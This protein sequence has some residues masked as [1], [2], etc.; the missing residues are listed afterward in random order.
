MQRIVT[1]RQIAKAK[2]NIDR[3][4]RTTICQHHVPMSEAKGCTT[5]DVPMTISRSA[6]F[7]STMRLKN[8]VGRDSL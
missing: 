5:N 1:N 6:C 3:N 2:P 8:R 7:K 4:H